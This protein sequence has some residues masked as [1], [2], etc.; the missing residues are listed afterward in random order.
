MKNWHD[1]DANSS[2]ESRT[3]RMNSCTNLVCTKNNRLLSDDEVDMTVTLRMNR[4]FMQ[5]IRLSV[6]VYIHTP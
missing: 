6:Q 3:E 1:E 4:D 2:V 5:H